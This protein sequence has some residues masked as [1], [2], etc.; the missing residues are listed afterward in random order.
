LA[1]YSGQFSL[2]A[3]ASGPAG[4]VTFVSIHNQLFLK[5][6]QGNI[7]L[8]RMVNDVFRAVG[9]DAAGVHPFV[10][11]RSGPD[12]KGG[13]TN[14]SQG[15]RWYAAK[16]FTEP[17]QPPAPKEYASYVGHFV[18]NGPEGPVARV[19]VRNGRLMM[20]LSE[21]EE[22]TPEPLQALAPGLFRIGDADYSPERARF[23]SVV[24]GQAL[25]LLISGVPLY[26]KDIS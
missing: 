8:E 15:A 12:G 10:F 5:S 25:R 3:G 22:A 2:G 18:S 9:G 7:P 26:R 19:F 6:A 24:D 16:N 21:D 20:L 4:S 1:R 11:A 23:D 17:L 14:V 13:V